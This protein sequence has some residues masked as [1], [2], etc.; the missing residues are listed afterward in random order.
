MSAD[1]LAQDATASTKGTIYQLCVAVQKCYEMVAGQKVLIESMGDVT[2]PGAQQVE[3]KL[4]VDVLTDNHPNFW[5]TLHNWM[6]DGFDST[7]YAALILYTTQQFGERATISE[8]NRSTPDQ[9]R[10][11]LEAINQSAET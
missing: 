2:I 8:W 3:T 4:Y 5:N 11:I 10:A 6:Q 1:K 7:Q 9:R